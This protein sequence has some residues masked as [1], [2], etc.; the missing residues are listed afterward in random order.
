MGNK[1]L[2][3]TLAAMI[4]AVGLAV[5]AT[6]AT[7]V[8]EEQPSLSEDNQTVVIHQNTGDMKWHWSGGPNHSSHSSHSSHA[9]HSSSPIWRP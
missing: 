5:S 9:S 7:S 8:A 2:N 6:A 1:N 4:G 3:A